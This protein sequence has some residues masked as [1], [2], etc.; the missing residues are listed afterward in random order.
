MKNERGITLIALIITIIVMLILVAVTVT[1]ALEGGLFDNAKE[2]VEKTEPQAIYEI[3][4][5]AM[6]LDANGDI[7]IASTTTGAIA[8]LSKEYDDANNQVREY[9]GFTGVIEV[10]GKYDTY[11]YE[12]TKTYIRQIDK[13]TAP[14]IVWPEL[15]PEQET[16]IKAAEDG[17]DYNVFEEG[18]S[19]DGVVY[20]EG[21]VE[22]YT[23]VATDDVMIYTIKNDTENVK[24]WIVN[25]QYSDGDEDWAAYMRFHGGNVATM[26]RRI[27]GLWN[28]KSC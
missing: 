16:E 20:D 11:Y 26:V 4:V 10:P 22:Y 15:T 17:Y 24:G 7:D 23:I 12:I 6:E 19:S 1:V 28:I 3:I 2:A 25:I 21:I 14:T 9:P 18:E 8:T 27:S 13:P 5:S